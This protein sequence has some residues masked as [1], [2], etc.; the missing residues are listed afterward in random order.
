MKFD[1]RI[2]NFL[3]IIILSLATFWWTSFIFHVDFAWDVVCVI[4]VLRVIAS[5]YIKNDYTLS[6]S[7]KLFY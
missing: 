1:K 6:W 3:V 4:I 5:R 2:L 7:K